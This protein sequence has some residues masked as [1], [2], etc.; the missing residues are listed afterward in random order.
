[1]L[2]IFTKGCVCMRLTQDER[3]DFVVEVE[4]SINYFEALLS[5]T[6]TQDER[7]KMQNAIQALKELTLV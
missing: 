1:M 6:E 2:K 3:I 4:T 5:Q 7:T